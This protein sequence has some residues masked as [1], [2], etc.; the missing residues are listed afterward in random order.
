MYVFKKVN[1]ILPSSVRLKKLSLPD[2]SDVVLE[3][4]LTAALKL[5]ITFIIIA[6]L[7]QNKDVNKTIKEQTSF[8]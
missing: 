3:A 5:K 1:S 4:E 6:F 8:M 2:I 7:T